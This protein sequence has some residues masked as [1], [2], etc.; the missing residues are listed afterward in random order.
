[1]VMHPTGLR[2]VPGSI[3]GSDKDILS[4]NF[5]F[6]VEVYLLFGPKHII[7]N[8]FV[9]NFVIPFAMLIH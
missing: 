5:R 8:D 2:E 3:P 1:M 7:F 6:V 9:F 4:L